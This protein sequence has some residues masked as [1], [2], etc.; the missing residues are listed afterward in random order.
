MASGESGYQAKTFRA[1][2]KAMSA[3]DQQTKHYD[4]YIILQPGGKNNGHGQKWLRYG[5]LCREK[6][7]GWEA[8]YF[9]LPEPER[10][11]YAYEALYQD[12]FR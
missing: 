6:W 7:T 1:R 5:K 11:W 12:L 10:C 3:S 9:P 4:R 2:N 8:Y